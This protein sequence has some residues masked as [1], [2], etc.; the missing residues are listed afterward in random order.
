MGKRL[1]KKIRI[2]VGLVVLVT[3]IMTAMAGI[4][5]AKTVTF[6]LSADFRETEKIEK[7]FP[8]FE[9]ETGIQVKTDYLPS[10]DMTKKMLLVSVTDPGAYDVFQVNDE[11]FYT[12]AP[13][14]LSLNKFIERDFGSV[15]NW[16]QMFAPTLEG[17][18][19][20]GQVKMYPLITHFQLGAY[21]K[22]KFE[23]SQERK[24]F[25]ERFGYDLPSPPEALQELVDVAKHFTRDTDGDGEIDEWGLLFGG[26]GDPAQCVFEHMF[27]SWGLSYYKE[28]DGKY[29]VIGKDPEA[30]EKF[31]EIATFLQDLALKYKVLPPGITGIAWETFAMFGTG[32]Y[33]MH[34]GWSQSEKINWESPEMKEKIGEVGWWMWPSPY[35]AFEGGWTGYWSYGIS[36]DSKDPEAAWEFLKWFLS[37]DTLKRGASGGWLWVNKEVFEH[38]IKLGEVPEV[39]ARG[40]QTAR[41]LLGI[42][43]FKMIR[44]VTGAKIDKLLAGKIMPTQWVDEW[45][46][47]IEDVLKSMELPI[48]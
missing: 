44:D 35:P 46:Q 5:N 48:Y 7:L 1:F 20:D 25:K 27:Y 21:L 33:A 29:K 17:V 8:E 45:A 13:R 11:S 18:I 30:R 39:T 15:E 41:P 37:A 32:K 16:K 26:K 42:P 23:D 9:A 2:G 28:I 19:F 12:M 40:A 34:F 14:L 6:L 10:T 43:G 31:I 38:M 36:K 4:G 47:G 22:S 24:A 3:L